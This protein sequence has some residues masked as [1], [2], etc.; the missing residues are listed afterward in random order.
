MPLEPLKIAPGASRENTR[1]T[2][3]GRWWDMDRVRFRSGTP[4][5]IGGWTLYLG[6]IV[7]GVPR[8]LKPWVTLAGEPLLAVGTNLKM[9]I[10]AGGEVFDA[11]PVRVTLSG[12]TNPFTSGALGSAVVT[13]TITS[14]NANTGDFVTFSGA[15]GF[16]GIFANSLNTIF[17]I[18]VLTLNTFTIV[19]TSCAVGGAV[20]GGTVTA[21]FQMD[22]SP[23]TATLGIGYGAGGYGANAYGT[24]SGGFLLQQFIGTSYGQDFIFCA[25]TDGVF[26]WAAG[27]TSNLYSALSTPAVALW[28]LAVGYGETAAPTQANYLVVTDDGSVIVG[29]ATPAAALVSGAAC[30]FAS[31]TMTCTTAPTIGAFAVG[32]VVFGTGL[33]LD[34]HIIALGTGL[35]GLGTYTM[36]TTTNTLAGVA[37]QCNQDID[38]MLVR[39]SG[40]GN[41]YLWTAA[42]TNTAGDQRLHNG[43]YIVSMTRMRQETLIFTDTAVISMQPVGPPIVYSFTTLATNTSI[44]SARAVAVA[45]NMAFWMGAG[46]FYVYDG[47]V[48]TLDCAVR[49]YIFSNINTTQYQQVCAGTT[50]QFNE[51]I[52]YYCS[53]ASTTPDRYV[54]YNYVEQ[55]WYYG[56]VGRTAWVDSP[57]LGGAVG[58]SATGQLYLH[59]S[60]VDDGSTTP[61]QSLNSYIESAALEIGNG[62]A[63]SFVSRVIPDIDFSQSTTTAPQVT[64][65]IKAA[66]A[67]GADF[68]Q[69]QGNTIA[70]TSS[71]PVT[72]FTNYAYVRVRGRTIVYRI[73]CN[74]PGSHWQLGTARID[75]RPDGRR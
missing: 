49:K 22:T 7:L 31:T 36:D 2:N 62:D 32:Q 5:A 34:Y 3:E 16:D 58:G 45:M 75:V 33:P 63:F 21:V 28:S 68:A 72:Q 1:Y 69:T 39:W 24:S 30:S 73:D 35:G 44:V 13:V 38:P 19:V 50:T 6:S 54:V 47:Q 4:E 42:I 48:H 74:T 26:Y 29:G 55:L 11:T 67:P 23:T 17:Q 10:V 14:H 40:Q 51:V 64:L 37:V 52:W 18:T 20:G 57:L 61:P 71:T 12:L 25:Q 9:Y 8:L 41:P 59:E 70:Q 60:G 15:T 27:P 53:A 56:T 66:Q 65:T 46:K 43:S